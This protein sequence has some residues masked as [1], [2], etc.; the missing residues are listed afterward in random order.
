MKILVVDDDSSICRLI[1]LMLTKNYPQAHVK[2]TFNGAH[3]IEM[4]YE[5]IFIPDIVICDFKMPELNGIQTAAWIKNWAHSK[6][7][8]I[9]FLLVSS[10]YNP[11]NDAFAYIDDFMKKPFHFN[12]LIHKTNYLKTQAANHLSKRTETAP[13]L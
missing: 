6:N 5:E 9:A 13:C 2:T 1:E 11:Q 3:A 10:S 7:K 4:I 12:T 8:A